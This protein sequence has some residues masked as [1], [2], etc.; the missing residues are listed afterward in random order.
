M[1]GAI[2]FVRRLSGRFALLAQGVLTVSRLQNESANF[3]FGFA[4]K[5]EFTGTPRVETEFLLL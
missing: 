2:D 4:E 5:R 1:E 3:T